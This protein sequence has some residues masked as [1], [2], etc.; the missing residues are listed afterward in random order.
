[1]HD[2]LSELGDGWR[3]GTAVALATVVATFQSAPRAPG[4][5]MAIRQDGSVAGSLSGGCIES[6]VYEAAQDVLGGS[7]PRLVRYGDTVDEPLDAGL[8]CGGSIDVFIESLAA[9]TFPDFDRLLGELAGDRCAA[10]A[11]VVDHRDPQRIGQHWLIGPAG[12]TLDEPTIAGALLADVRQALDAAV[13]ICLSY[14]ADGRRGGTEMRVFIRSYT[15]R[16]RLIIFGANDFAASLAHL[17]VELGYHVTVCDARPVFATAQRIPDADEVVVEWPHRYLGSECAAG[18][19]DEHTALVVMTHD[20]KFDVPLLAAALRIPALGY[21][22]AM[23]SRRTHRHRRDALRERGFRDVE[24][25]RLHSPIGLD[26][27]AKTPMETAV[28]I[29]AE[30]VAHRSGRS[31]KRLATTTAGIHVPAQDISST[32][33][34]RWSGTAD[35]QSAGLSSR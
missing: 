18:E 5:T 4:S 12:A 21:L 27:G 20:D 29:A 10:V 15:R 35:R 2:I 33:S 22:G 7:P 30:M 6:A 28:S 19:I 24:L 17:G 31:G 8:T 14:T 11:T 13:N 16:P 9:A 1:M 3:Q 23:G 25:A 26:L 32:P 34:A